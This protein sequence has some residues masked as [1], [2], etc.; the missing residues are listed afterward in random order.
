MPCHMGHTLME[1]RHGLIV[2]TELTRADGNADGEAVGAEM[3]AGVLD[4]AELRWD[5]AGAA[6]G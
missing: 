6:E 5:G 4:R 1:N 2:Q 3:G